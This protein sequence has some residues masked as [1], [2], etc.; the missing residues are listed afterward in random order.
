MPS[1]SLAQAVHAVAER[2]AVDAEACSRV[3][4]AAAALEQGRERVDECVVLG[5]VAEYAVDER[6]ERGVRKA[7]DQLQRS[8]VAVGG[9]GARRLQ[10]GPRLG[11]AATDRPARG[12]PA[13]ADPPRGAEGSQP[14]R[15][16]E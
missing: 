9:D 3:A 11:Q 2:V 12:R 16:I 5:G 6:L 15:E 14:F 7:E 8:E 13:D 1:R 4:P 10:G